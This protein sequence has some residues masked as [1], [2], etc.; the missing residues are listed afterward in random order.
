[1]R[2]LER[3]RM[4]VKQVG[5][6]S[7]F[8]VTARS[9][10]AALEGLAKSETSALQKELE[11]IFDKIIQHFRTMVSNKVKDESEE[12]VRESLREHFRLHPT[13][14]ED[15]KKRLGEIEAKYA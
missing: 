7:P 1:M 6:G 10:V 8:V 5:E 14:A 12:P 2:V 4:Q 3:F 13:I 15:L 11:A 9:I